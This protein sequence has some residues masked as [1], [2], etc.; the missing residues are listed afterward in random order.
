MTLRHPMDIYQ[1][2]F[3]KLEKLLPNLCNLSNAMKL[4]APGYMDLNVEVLERRDLKL[5]IALSH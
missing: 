4:K 1:A 2:N 3:K 5:V